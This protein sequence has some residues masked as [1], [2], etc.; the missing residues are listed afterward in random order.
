ME[1]SLDH[2]WVSLNFQFV[3]I[4]NYLGEGPFGKPVGDFLIRLFEA[5]RPTLSLYGWQCS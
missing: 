3:D 4:Y 5:R 1:T 2:D